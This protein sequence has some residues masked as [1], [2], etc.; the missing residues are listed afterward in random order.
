MR[1]EFYKAGLIC[2]KKI[3]GNSRPTTGAGTVLLGALRIY[4][5][6][7]NNKNFEWKT[8]ATMHQSRRQ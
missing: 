4:F 2:P 7:N 6:T 1:V 5:R 3:L 8:V